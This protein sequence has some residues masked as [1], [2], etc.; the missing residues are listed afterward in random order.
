MSGSLQELTRSKRDKQPRWRLKV[1]V[2]RDPQRTVRDPVT[3]KIK[4]GPPIFKSEVFH[5]KK[6][7]ARDR[8]NALVVEVQRGQHVGSTSTLDTLLDR[9]LKHLQQLG[10]A[11]STLET[12]QTHVDK[13]IRPVLGSV[14]LDKLDLE[15]I[16]AYLG[17]LREKGLAPRTIKTNHAVLSAALSQGVKWKLLPANPAAGAALVTA[18]T[19]ATSITIDQLR[20]LYKVA[21]G[22]DVDMAAC[23]A[24]GAITGARRGELCGL[25]WYDL[26]RDRATLTIERAWVPGKGGQHLTTTKTGKSR[27]VFIG[28]AGVAFLD[29]YRQLQRER[30]GGAE[31]DGWLLSLN[32]G[33]TPLRA[34]SVS[35]YMTA[36]A[37]KLKIPVHFHTLRHLAAS[38]LQANGVDLATAA[39]QLG[40]SPEVMAATY[41]HSTDE[42]GAAAGELLSGVV[43]NALDA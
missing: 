4:H 30:M 12:Y 7:E 39:R 26:D 27:T 2:G 31:P 25:Q 13:H 36:L 18:R 8:L 43:V 11:T 22:D 34:K 21:L 19:E 17:T 15:R 9:W 37:K 32:G 35:E 28:A 38:E 33:V 24:L 3:G 6:S 1:Y 23:I 41:L 14:R 10:K 5:G 42:R 40:H 20:D 16:D 29:G